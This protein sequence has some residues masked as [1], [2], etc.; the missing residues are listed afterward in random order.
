MVGELRSVK[1]IHIDI[2][3]R[4]VVSSV[5]SGPYFLIS[6]GLELL[7]AEASVLLDVITL[8]GQRIGA[9]EN[10]STALSG[11]SCIAKT[12]LPSRGLSL[13]TTGNR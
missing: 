11:M 5:K 2:L 4:I 10:Q 7:L 13:I 1:Q 12:P 9:L 6:E 3:L 8:D